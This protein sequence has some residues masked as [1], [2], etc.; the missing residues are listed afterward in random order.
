[1]VKERIQKV[2]AAA[3]VTSRRK[4]E[5]LIQ[6]GRVMVDGRRVTR[7][8][9]TVDPAINVLTVD[10]KRINPAVQKTYLLLNKPRGY[11][12]SLDDPQQRKTVMDLVATVRGRVFPVGRL[13]YD[14][15]GLL[16]F[17][18]DG[19]L[20][21]RLLHP[22]FMI[23]RTYLV[24]VKGCPSPQAVKRLRSGLR[25]ADG[26]TRPAH[27]RLI[28]KTDKNSWITITVTEGRNNLIKR[29]F[30]SVGN[31]VLKLKRIRFGSLTLGDLP[32]GHYRFLR[33][34]EIAGLIGAGAE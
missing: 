18:N 15:E 14:A 3:G 23:P 25:L 21:N 31:R 32:T 22:K 7:L 2:I 5:D 10:G 17:T 8:G 20:A 24:K 27:V 30:D 16:L 29:M 12:T 6:E 13:D 34:E 33:S 19:E 1:M 26:P 11:I 9:S 28:D 4:A